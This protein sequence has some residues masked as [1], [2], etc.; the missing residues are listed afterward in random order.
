[1]KI[2]TLIHFVLLVASSASI[3]NQWVSYSDELQFMYV[4]ACK[5]YAA[6]ISYCESIGGALASASTSSLRSFLMDMV[7]GTSTSGSCSGWN[8]VFTG[9]TLN[10]ATVEWVD[11]TTTPSNEMDWD[12]SE[13]NNLS[14]QKG[15]GF[16]I[17]TKKWHSVALGSD[18]NSFFCSKETT[19]NP[20]YSPTEEPSIES[21]CIQCNCN[22]NY[23]G[24]TSSPS[25][26]PQAVTQNL[27]K[28][29]RQG[30]ILW[31]KRM[32]KTMFNARMEPKIYFY[33]QSLLV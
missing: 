7:T 28:R 6:S 22:C 14:T 26:Y 30:I 20:T 33:L 16:K 18:Y 24:E 3:P 11:G 9:G 2:R 29:S 15:V 32:T 5:N 1:M 10:G 13:P 8:G 23:Y 12:S 25:D 27:R 17:S 19:T 4:T 21:S 31:I